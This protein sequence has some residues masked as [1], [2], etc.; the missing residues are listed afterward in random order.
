MKQKNDLCVISLKLNDVLL[1]QLT[2]EIVNIL[3]MNTIIEKKNIQYENKSVLI[4]MDK[5]QKL[6]TVV[7]YVY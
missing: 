7:K 2:D 3:A 5:S 4:T 6:K 1:H